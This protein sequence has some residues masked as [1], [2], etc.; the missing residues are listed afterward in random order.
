MGA[1]VA[2]KTDFNRINIL[3]VYEEMAAIRRP[4]LMRKA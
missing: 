4:L 2:H 1:Q 3:P